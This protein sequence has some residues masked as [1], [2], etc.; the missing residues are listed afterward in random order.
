[1]I[2]GARDRRRR[3]SGLTASVVSLKPL[4]GF[5]RARGVDTTALLA[6]LG[7]ELS[8][9]DDIDR[10]ISEFDK[11]RLWHEVAIQAKDVAFGLHVAQFAPVGALDVLDYSLCYSATLGDA[12][13][14]I[15][16]FHRV[17]SDVCAFDLDTRGGVVHLRRTLETPERHSVEALCALVVLRAR[18]ITTRDISPRFVRF[19]HSRPSDTKQHTALFSCPV[20]FECA[21]TELAFESADLMLPSSRADAGLVEVLDRHMRDLLDRLPHADEFIQAV[22]RAVAHALRGG[23]PTLASTARAIGA[24]TRTVQRRLH[25]RGITHRSVVDDVRR[26]LAER[27]VGASRHPLTEIAFLVGFAELSGFQRTFRRWTGL[28]PC[29]FRA[30]KR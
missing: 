2:A 26:E 28:S 12:I 11:E 21:T 20:H 6:Q 10:R 27:L 29:E 14:R 3:L 30:A 13:D 22:H 1:V 4:L 8:N 18:R 15:L 17:L 23:R 9:L 24:T 25:E 7:L 16:Q 19:S 5:A